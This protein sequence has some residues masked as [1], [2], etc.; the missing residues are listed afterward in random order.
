ML[1]LPASGDGAAFAFGMM[2]HL[3]SKVCAAAGFACIPI[4]AEIVAIAIRESR[5]MI[6][7]QTN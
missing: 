5:R 6:A 2:D 3:S 7:S 1:F 4:H